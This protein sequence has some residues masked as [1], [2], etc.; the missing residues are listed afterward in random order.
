MRLQAPRSLTVRLAL[1]FALAT[2]LTFT[3]VGSYLYY[4][5]AR[6]LEHH[7]DQELMGKI[8][9]MRHLAAKARSVQAIRDDP[10]SFMDATLGHDDLLLILRSADGAPLLDT[11]PEAGSLPALPMTAAGQVPDEK[12]R[13]NLRTSAGLPVRATALWASIDN[14][15]EKMQIIVAHNTSDSIAMLAS[16]RQQILGA[17]LSGAILAALLGYVL[18]RRGLRPARLIAQQAH[19]ITAQRLDR[20]LDVASAP[21]ELQQLVVAFNGML[22]RLHDSFQRLSQFSADLAHDLRTPIN[23]LMVQTQVALAQPRLP[24]EYQGLLVSNVEEYERLARMLDNMLFLARADHAHVAVAFGQLDC[25]LELERIADYFEG[26]A[27]DSGVRLEIAA[28]GSIR[29]DAMLLRRAISNLVA[30]AIRYTAAGQTI[31][32]GAAQAGQETVISVSNPGPQI[33]DSAVPRLFDR[34]Y[35]ADPARSD[36]ASSAGLGLAIVQ[37]IMKLHGGR[38]ELS[39]SADQMTVFK[40]H[41]PADR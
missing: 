31:V 39:R 1:L 17:A 33:A 37:S 8:T 12:S 32:L 15:G 40:L 20:G 16:Y 18:V 7:D 29:A 22:D 9:L 26:V 23:N 36:S 5:L 25:Q 19:S 2:L 24:E 41:F 28:S 11:R 13:Q 27:E 30:N 3:M 4:S 14:S 38:V 6:Q 21:Y 35:R 10:H 34:F